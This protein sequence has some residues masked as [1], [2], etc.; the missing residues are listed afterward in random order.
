[1]KTLIDTEICLTKN[2][3]FEKKKA[4]NHCELLFGAIVISN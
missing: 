4:T 1:M 2:N 3:D